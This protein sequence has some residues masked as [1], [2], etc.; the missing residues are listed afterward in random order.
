MKYV[1]SIKHRE[2]SRITLRNYLW[3]AGSTDPAINVVVG[4]GVNWLREKM[5]IYSFISLDLDN[6]ANNP[7]NFCL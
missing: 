4:A 2:R 1:N 7:P 3:L 5:I 6:S